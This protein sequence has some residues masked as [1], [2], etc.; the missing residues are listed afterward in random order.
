M[1]RIF[2]LLEEQKY[3]KM[4]SLIFLFQ[5]LREILVHNSQQIPLEN[6]ICH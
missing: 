1:F 2:V 3:I 5:T 4:V 6:K